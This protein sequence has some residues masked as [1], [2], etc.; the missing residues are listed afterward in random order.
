MLLSMLVLRRALQNSLIVTSFVRLQSLK[1]RMSMSH[2]KDDIANV[3]KDYR[4]EDNVFL[5]TDLASKDPLKL[6]DVWLDFACNTAGILEPNAM[7]LATIKPDGRPSARMVLLKGYDEN[8]FRFFSNYR[9]AKA[10]AIDSSPFVALVFYWV[11]L[12]RSIRIEG[13]IEKLSTK[14]ADEYFAQ[15]PRRSQIAAHVSQHQSAPIENRDVLLSR[16]ADIEGTYPDEETVPR[17]E[18]WGGY[19]VRPDMIEFWQGQR[20]RM[21]DRIVFRKKEDATGEFIH[22]GENGWVYQRLEP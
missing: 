6:F 3:R 12:S 16:R 13:R 9:S 18:Y 15:R 11:E 22:E 7:T 8:G 17:P 21:H 5:E 2:M 19:L 20:T 10:K 14:D 4:S 1:C